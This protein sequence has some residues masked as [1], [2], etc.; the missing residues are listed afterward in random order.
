[1][2][3]RLGI[4]LVVLWRCLFVRFLNKGNNQQPLGWN[5]VGTQGS[6]FANIGDLKGTKHYQEMPPEVKKVLQE[7]E[8]R[9]Q[10]EKAVIEQNRKHLAAPLPQ[11]AKDLKVRWRDSLLFLCSH[12]QNK[13][14]VEAKLD[15]W[16]EHL[17]R[18]YEKVQDFRSSV[19]KE[20]RSAETAYFLLKG[21]VSN[22]YYEQKDLEDQTLPSEYF[23]DLSN[24]FEKRMQECRQRIDE[25]E[26]YLISARNPRHYTPKVRWG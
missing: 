6:A 1:M 26:L 23:R 21:L 11:L 2:Q 8:K 20:L 4:A 7:V 9:F 13:K 24:S 15:Q 5:T 10:N 14:T 22:T 17:E 16:M 3:R 12:K 25:L 18:Q 19:N